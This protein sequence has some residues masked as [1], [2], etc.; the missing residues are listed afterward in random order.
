MGSFWTCRLEKAGVTDFWGATDLEIMS[1]EPITLKQRLM[2]TFQDEDGLDY[3][4]VSREFFWLL[5]HELFSPQ[6]C[7]FEYSTA[8]N[9]TLQINPKSFINPDHLD[10]CREVL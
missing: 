6:Y 7:L 3:S 8:D 4:G 1:C 9:Y 2:V 10:W 5:S